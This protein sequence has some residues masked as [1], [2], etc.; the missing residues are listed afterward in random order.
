MQSRLRKPGLLAVSALGLMIVSAQSFGQEALPVKAPDAKAANPAQGLQLEEPPA[1]FV[2]ARPERVEERET[3]ELAEMFVAARAHEARREWTEALEL[4]DKCAAIAPDNLAVLKRQSRLNLALGKVDKGLE[5]SRKALTI[6]PGDVDSLRLLVGLYERRNQ[7][8]QA[9]KLLSDTLANPKLDQKS[10]AALYAHFARGLLFAGRLQQPQKA[11]DSMIKVMDLLD[12]KQA[13]L[14]NSLEANRILGADPARMYLNFGRVFAASQRWDQASRAF[15]RGL[16]YNPD[17]N[18]MVVLLVTSLLEDGKAP[19]A[20]SQLENAFR[21]KPDA[22]EIYELLPRVLAALKRSDETIRRL[23]SLSASIPNNPGII[24]VLADQYRDAGQADKARTLYD[25][26]VRIRPDPQ[27]F[28]TLAAGLIKDKKYDGFLD[29]LARA[30]T[31][32]R[33]L[34]SL[35]PQLESLAVNSTE[36]GA[37]L[38]AA[39]KRL[40]SDPKSF[41]KQTYSSL[42]YLARQA[43]LWDRLVKLRNLAAKAD[44]SAES[45]RE[46][47]L[48]Y[49]ESGQFAEAVRVINEIFDKF[50]NEKDRRNLVMLAQFQIFA[51]QSAEALKT[52]EAVLKG[53][54]NDPTALRW[55]IFTLSDLSRFDEAVK[56][57]REVLA[58]AP[59]DA[60]F[61][62]AVGGALTR[63]QKDEEAISFYRDLLKQYPANI[64]LAKVAHS[65]LSVIYVNRDDFASGEK[66]L[67]DLL[68]RVPDDPGVNNDLGYLYADQGK[69]LEE[70][71]GMVRKAIAEDPENSAYLDSL[72][73]VL[74][75][76]GKYEEALRYMEKAISIARRSS[77]DGTLFD[78]LGDI[79]FRLKMFDKAREAWAE[80]QKHIDPGNLGEKLSQSL[81]TKLENLDRLPAQVKVSGDTEP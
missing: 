12:D 68:K 14:G 35:R 71:E 42:F 36:A 48:T 16:S 77:P 49:Y 50:P 56:L 74:Y 75:K 26:L 23:E 70:A 19:A 79:Y 81:K 10:A 38:D 53:D 11:V 25:E 27:G 3:T 29:L 22:R 6:E 24:S 69:R 15:E 30:M 60:D 37:V 55:K 73:W 76:R 2:P 5:I 17:E 18:L 62:R 47:A 67:E 43:E 21:R 4:L 39:I 8:P 28:A 33:G 80:A 64:E 20:L 58:K 32:P 52:L 51:K 66:E 13:G 31:N 46:L 44:P 1:L 45:M 7:F 34:E 72:A 78:H 61:N 41:Q 65:G 54:P 9:E 40:D 57:G 59:E 63:A